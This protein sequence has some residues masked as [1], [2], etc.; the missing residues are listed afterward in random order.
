VIEACQTVELAQTGF[1]IDERLRDF[2]IVAV[3]CGASCG[4]GCESLNA[5]VERTGVD[6]VDRWVG[7]EEVLGQLL[8]LRDAIAGESW[9]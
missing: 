4:E 7:G 8:G 1:E 5:A 3:L 2:G 6:S 9:V